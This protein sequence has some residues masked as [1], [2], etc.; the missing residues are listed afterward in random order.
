MKFKSQS[1]DSLAEFKENDQIM[2]KDIH[3]DQPSL[4]AIADDKFNLNK[5][6]KDKTQNKLMSNI[7]GSQD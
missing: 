4:R 7:V 5:L 1:L 3:E 6:E 2:N